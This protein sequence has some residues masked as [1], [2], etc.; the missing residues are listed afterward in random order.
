MRLL[1]T[2][3]SGQV[4]GALLPLL[5]PLGELV[6]PQ[7]HQLDLEN[8]DSIIDLMRTFKPDLVINAAAYTAVDKAEEEHERALAIN[9]R[10]PGILAEEA[11]RLGAMLVHYS[12]DYVFEG[13]GEK[14]W[15]EDDPAKPVNRYGESKLAGEQ[16]V[17]AA[18]DRW[19]LFRTSWVYGLTGHNFLRT[20]LRLSRERDH[21]RVVDDQIG[22][23]TWSSAIAA[24][25][26]SALSR[27]TPLQGLYHLA[28]GGETSW[29]GFARRIMV[30]TGSPCQVEPIT[31]AEYP[32]PAPRPLNS[33]LDTS[34][35][36]AEG[37]RPDHWESALHACLAARQI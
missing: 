24:A 30:E 35:L 11:R 8:P 33:R 15:R 34:R 6:A 26:L 21:L 37:I 12:T 36:A 32:L 28:N 1:L 16:A 10:A 29:A 19:L 25:T 9:G 7:R 17:V 3:A 18:A 27:R 22:A 13:G 23:P 14:S 20:M 4:G 31:S 5:R 2:G